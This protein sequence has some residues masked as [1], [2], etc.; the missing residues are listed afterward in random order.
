MFRT[1]RILPVIHGLTHEEVTTLWPLL[2]ARVAAYSSIG[3]D[4]VAAKVALALRDVDVSPHAV[5]SQLYNVKDARS[6]NFVGRHAELDDLAALL[7]RS[8][9]VRVAAAVEGLAGIGKTELA[10]QLVYLLAE[11]GAFPGGVFWFDAQAPD[12]TATWGQSIAD[13]M[14]LPPGTS[15]ERAALAV[16]TVSRRNAPVLIVLDNVEIWSAET[17]PA[18][19]PEGPHIRFLITSRHNGIGGS[20][21]QHFEVG[22]LAP[23]FARE[24]LCSTAGRDLASR[25]GFADLLDHLGGHALA[26][27]LA[28][29]F[30]RE[31]PAETPATYLAALRRSP[32]IEAKVSELTR[33][34]R[35]VSAAFQT[36]WD[37]LDDETRRAWQV[38]ARFEP[39]FATPALAAAAGLDADRLRALRRFHLIEYDAEGS[40]RMHRLIGAFGRRTGSPAELSAAELAFVRGCCRHADAI[41]LETGFRVYVPDRVHFDAAMQRAEDALVDDAEAFTLF[42][43]RIGTA[44]HCL[45]QLKSAKS[46]FSQAL[47]LALVTFGEDHPKVAALRSNF[48]LVLRDLGELPSARALLE[49]ALAFYAR[50]LGEDHP[51]VATCRSNLAMVLLNLGDLATARALLEQALASDLRNF[52]EDHRLVALRR[53]N[54]ASVLYSLGEPTNARALLEQ[55]LAFYLGAFGEDHPTV[56]R[57]RSNLAAVLRSLGELTYARALL[58]QALAANLRTFGEDHPNVATPRFNLALIYLTEGRNNAAR[59]LLELTLKAELSALGS[60]NPSVALTRARLAQALLGMGD[61]EGAEREAREALRIVQS[62]PAGSTFRRE[63]EELVAPLIGSD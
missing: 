25:P 13:A 31:F 37:R 3:P 9:G 20:R 2:A 32:D 57:C 54:L 4:E 45:G 21:F 24:L 48:A 44:H 40:W 39:A 49:Q 38:A 14:G 62:Q 63:V 27:E 34:E 15:V 16:R 58:E 52:E 7:D 43:N 29:A 23:P 5:R 60:E 53:T 42:L 33:Y 26:L 41:D 17:A 10:L 61:S 28:G 8:G 1:K 55:A 19:L 6:A 51:S 22:V 50:S 12:L 46:T 59:V 18:P 30:L 47:D 11:R 36:V 56:A 35:T